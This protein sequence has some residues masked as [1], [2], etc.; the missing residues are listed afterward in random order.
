MTRQMLPSR[1]L[2]SASDAQPATPLIMLDKEWALPEGRTL[3]M[4]AGGLDAKRCRTPTPESQALLVRYIWQQSLWHGLAQA[5]ARRCLHCCG[6]PN[7]L[8][9][10]PTNMERDKRMLGQVH[11][12]GS[13]VRDTL[14]TRTNARCVSLERPQASTQTV[15]TNTCHVC[16]RSLGLALI[17]AS[18]TE[19]SDSLAM[20]KGVGVPPAVADK[21]DGKWDAS[22]CAHSHSL[23]AT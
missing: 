10:D 15:H 20:I 22:G 4:G 13:V 16:D 7:G 5:F 9:G 3:Q 11:A 18:E 2:A 12:R 19:L 17:N 1:R 8:V 6:A 21:D 23:R 14:P